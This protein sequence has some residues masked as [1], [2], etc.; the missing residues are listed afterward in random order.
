MNESS[1]ASATELFAHLFEIGNAYE[2][3]L[4]TKDV[5]KWKQ[6]YFSPVMML[7]MTTVQLRF[8]D[9]LVDEQQKIKSFYMKQ[10]LDWFPITSKKKEDRLPNNF[11]S[12]DINQKCSYADLIYDVFFNNSRLNLAHG[13]TQ[14]QIRRWAKQFGLSVDDINFDSPGKLFASDIAI[15]RRKVAEACMFFL[16][17]QGIS[18]TICLHPLG[19]IEKSWFT[20]MT[21]EYVVRNLSMPIDTCPELKLANA[22]RVPIQ[23]G[24]IPTE[25]NPI[26]FYLA[27]SEKD[28]AA[29]RAM[30]LK[31]MPL[32]QFEHDPEFLKLSEEFKKACIGIYEDKPNN[33][34]LHFSNTLIPLT[35]KMK[36]LLNS[37]NITNVFIQ[38]K[39]KEW[40]NLFFYVSVF[41]EDVGGNTDMSRILTGVQTELKFTEL[42]HQS[43]VYIELLRRNVVPRMIEHAFFLMLLKDLPILNDELVFPVADY[44]RFKMYSLLRSQLIKDLPYKIYF[45]TNNEMASIWNPYTRMSSSNAVTFGAFQ[46]VQLEDLTKKDEIFQGFA[47]IASFFQTVIDQI[48]ALGCELVTY[49]P[50]KV[51]ANS[52]YFNVVLNLIQ[53]AFYQKKSSPNVYIPVKIRC[54]CAILAE[55]WRH[56]IKITYFD[57]IANKE[58]TTGYVTKSQKDSTQKPLKLNARMQLYRF[59]ILNPTVQILSE[60]T[61]E[62]SLTLITKDLIS[63]IQSVSFNVNEVE[64]CITSI[65]TYIKSLENS[66]EMD[67]A[68]KTNNVTVCQKC[69]KPKVL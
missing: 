19:T 69:R 29:Q 24:D 14:L 53:A 13:M 4:Q 64:R 11:E 35:K 20:P 43:I 23:P 17:V 32:N 37:T 34:I 18:E 6:I 30:E 8:N 22:N 45:G 50:N 68:A 7:T 36:Q 51:E 52:L 60:T 57:Y 15:A 27:L 10:F 67:L 2:L 12:A 65:F 59:E 55:L 3:L 33:A 31:N 46:P 40:Y 16:I 38:K 1:I 39:Q 28:A 47:T 58:N 5:E 63:A 49:Y 41:P 61:A 54:A 66:N 48:Y 62:T 44:I 42:G 56:F 25:M 21:K 9:L 26:V